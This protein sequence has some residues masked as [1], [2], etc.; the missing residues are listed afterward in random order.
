[1]RW[2]FS[3]KRHKR[4]KRGTTGDRPFKGEQCV[5]DAP[6]LAQRYKRREEGRGKRGDEK[7]SAS[8]KNTDERQ[9]AH[10]GGGRGWARTGGWGVR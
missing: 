2:D 4:H 6:V 5:G 9:N 10:G 1:M 7:M 8:H 3:H